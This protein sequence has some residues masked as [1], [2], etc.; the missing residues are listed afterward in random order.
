MWISSLRDF[1]RITKN[2]GLRQALS[3]TKDHAVRRSKNYVLRDGPTSKYS[4]SIL[5]P[6][7]HQQLYAY[8]DLGYWPQITQPRTFNEK[9][10]HRKLYT[11]NDDFRLSEDKKSVR[12]FV[13]EEVGDEYLPK[14]Y[15]VTD[16]PESIP[17][18]ELP[19]NYVI[20]PTVGSGDVVI[21][22]KNEI[23]IDRLKEKC[24]E[25]LSVEPSK[26][27]L[28]GQYWYENYV[29]E[30]I[31]EE[32]LLNDDGHAPFDYKFYVFNGTV[33]FMHVDMFRFNDHSRRFFNRNWKPQKF[34][35]GNI[36]LGPV[37]ETPNN[38]DEMLDIAESLGEGF[39]FIRVDLYNINDGRI[40]FGE[41]TPVPGGGRSPFTPREYDF[42]F[43][44]L[45]DI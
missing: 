6:K 14:L 7:L 43:G 8:P 3:L 42:K 28:S 41:L 32:S 34:R 22:D 31:I 18:D 24:H 40:V 37:I 39:D 11:K 19:Q 15:H 26:Y 13:K 10:L 45:W 9:I 23:D 2:Q 30:L 38:Y 1:A 25:L 5:G 21:V 35:K 17:F 36:P 27:T 12:R 4:K 44:E 33:E 16:N 20:K 29:P